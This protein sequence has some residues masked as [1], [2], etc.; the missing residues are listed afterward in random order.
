MKDET[1]FKN[2]MTLLGE[3]FGKEISD[4]LKTAYWSVLKPYTDGQCKAAFESVIATCRFFPKPAELLE[5]LG[6]GESDAATLAW[7]EVDR[8]VRQIGPY[9]SV[10]FEDPAINSTI[11][12]M[13]GWV[14]LGGV[15]LDQWK[16]SRKEF[17][18]LYPIMTRRRDGHPEYLPGVFELENSAKGFRV[19]DAKRIG[20]PKQKLKAITGGKGV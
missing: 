8:A 14:R 6:S 16:W 2:Y 4:T 12:A 3:I 11:E 10:S 1:M 5:L 7:L 13:G 15:T 19:P 20:P 17:E 9:E 18:G